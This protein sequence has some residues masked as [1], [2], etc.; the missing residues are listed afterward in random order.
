LNPSLLQR[1]LAPLLS[2]SVG[3]HACRDGTERLEVEDNCTLIGLRRTIEEKLGVPV[4]DQTLSMQ[5]GLL[6]TKNPDAFDDLKANVTT[7]R[8]SEP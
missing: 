4:A 2:S 7:T 5:Q 1:C 3:T 6:M 8:N